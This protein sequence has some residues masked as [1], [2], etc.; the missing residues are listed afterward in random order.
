M[1]VRIGKHKLNHYKTYLLLAYIAD[2]YGEMMS[3]DECMQSKNSDLLKVIDEI[4]NFISK[5]DEEA[6]VVQS[7]FIDLM[8]EVFYGDKEYILWNDFEIRDLYDYINY[9]LKED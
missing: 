3:T 8:Q 9:V 1:K 5:N 6:W 7:V 2:N 4:F